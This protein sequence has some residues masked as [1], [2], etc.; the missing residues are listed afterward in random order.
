VSFDVCAGETFGLLGPNGL[1]TATRGTPVPRPPWHGCWGQHRRHRVATAPRGGVRLRRR[2]R[3]EEEELE[4]VMPVV[5]RILAGLLLIAHG[6]VHLLYVASDVEEFTPD[7]SWIVGAN[8]RR[9]V[10]YALMT[11]TVAAFALV[12][13]A[14]WG[15]PL[16]S[17]V[18]PTLTIIASLA[19]LVLLILY[20]HPRLVFG[21]AID[22]VLIAVA[23]V[24]PAWTA[25]IG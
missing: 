11:V 3:Y 1:A 18:W 9:P 14:V 24:R 5:I 15:L 7:A 12:G 6:L 4:Q 19:S 20:W 21:V 10:A 17:A 2:R 23:V 25:S 22:L 13:F 8:A 16:L